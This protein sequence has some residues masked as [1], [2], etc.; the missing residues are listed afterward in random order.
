[1]S[2]DVVFLFFWKRHL[3]LP[4]MAALSC[5]VGRRMVEGKDT[6]LDAS[7]SDYRTYVLFSQEEFLRLDRSFM[8]VPYL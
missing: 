3:L 6:I 7:Q 1:M 4:I 5:A 2:F 8:T